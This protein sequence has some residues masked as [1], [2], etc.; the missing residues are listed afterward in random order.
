MA[1]YFDIYGKDKGAIESLIKKLQFNELSKKLHP[2]QPL[3]DMNLVLHNDRLK[4][5]KDTR[6]VHFK[7]DNHFVLKREGNPPVQMVLICQRFYEKENELLAYID[8]KNLLALGPEINGEMITT[9]SV[10]DK[11][12]KHKFQLNDSFLTEDVWGAYLT[13]DALSEKNQVPLQDIETVVLS[14]LPARKPN[15]REATDPNDKFIMKSSD[16]LNSQTD[17]QYSFVRGTI[18]W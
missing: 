14:V 4:R 2:D 17:H 5:L 18:E 10:A 9:L 6:F 7:K 12:G 13:F 3:I 16:F 8:E 11:N 1:F 15:T